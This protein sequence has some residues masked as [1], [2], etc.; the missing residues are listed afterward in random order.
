VPHYHFAQLHGGYGVAVDDG[1]EANNSVLRKQSA[2]CGYQDKR[3]Y[4]CYDFQFFHAPV[5]IQ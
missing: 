1:A 2:A 4:G 3:G 5:F